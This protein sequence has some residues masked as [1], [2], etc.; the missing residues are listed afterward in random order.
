M[1]TIEKYQT[2]SGATL[3][4]V[5]YRTPDNR[6]TQKR[7][8]KTKRDAER[9]AAT[10]EV[11]KMR[12]EYVAPSVGKITIGELGAA[13]LDRQRGHIKPSTSRSYEALEL[14][15]AP[16]WGRRASPTS[17]TPTCRRGWPSWPARGRSI[18]RCLLGAGADPRRRSEGPGAGGQP[19]PRGEAAK[20]PPRRNVY[21]TA[22]AVAR[23]SPTSP[24][25]TTR[26]CCC[27]VSAGCAGARPRRCACAMSTSCAA[28]STCTATR[29]RSAVTSSSASLKSN[30]NRTVA[31][32]AFVV[33][34]LAA[35]VEG[36]GRD[37]LMWPSASGGYLGAAVDADSWLSDAVARC[38][39]ADP[40]FPRI[41]AHAL[42]HTAASLAIRRGPTRRSCSGCWGTPVAAMTLDVYA[43][44]FES[45]L[46]RW[47]TG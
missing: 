18:V 20:P 30:K 27:S 17:A 40:T 37:E 9:F 8:F 45:D 24:A 23:G 16:R 15:V 47:P 34:E 28:G 14:H 13:W 1:A 41:T 29:S 12:G 22:D 4:R 33:D 7:G 35:T 39:K 36:K 32:P 42:R 19:G 46:D 3:Y 10:V 44:L 11:A 26:W 2:A 5:R 43:D 6:S 38:Q 21:L 31:L 25:A